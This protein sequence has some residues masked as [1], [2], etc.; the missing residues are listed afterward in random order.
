[1]PSDGAV[2]FGVFEVD[3]GA[4]ELRKRGVRVRMQDQPFRVL[5]A[6]LEKPGGESVARLRPWRLSVG[7]GGDA[8]QGRGAVATQSQAEAASS[9]ASGMASGAIDSTAASKRARV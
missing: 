5:E 9:S 4:R 3:L 7:V 8:W 1:M 2:R 6:L